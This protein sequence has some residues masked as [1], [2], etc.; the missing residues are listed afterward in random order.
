[1]V[2]EGIILLLLL[3]SQSTQPIRLLPS[4]KSSY[5]KSST[6]KINQSIDKNNPTVMHTAGFDYLVTIFSS[7]NSL[8]LIDQLTENSIEILEIGN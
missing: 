4:F 7:R 1:M 8:N 2:L 5:A 3:T 6:I